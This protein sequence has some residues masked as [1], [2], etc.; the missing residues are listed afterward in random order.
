MLQRNE[1]FIFCEKLNLERMMSSRL[2]WVVFF[3]LMV[4]S[5]VFRKAILAL[6]YLIFGSSSSDF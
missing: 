4:F 1:F 3:A 2:V 5:P 6:A